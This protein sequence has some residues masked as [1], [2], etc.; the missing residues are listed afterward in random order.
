MFDPCLLPQDAKVRRVDLAADLQFSD[1]EDASRFL[2]GLSVLKVPGLPKTDAWRCEG[3]IETVYHRLRSRKVRWRVYDK[4]A[5]RASED[6]ANGDA[7]APPQGWIRMERQLHLAKP[8]QVSPDLLDNQRLAGMWLGEL[9][10]WS[11]VATD[12]VAGGLP[13]AQRA[14]IAAAQQGAITHAQ[15][16]R[17]LGHVALSAS[18]LAEQFW[19]GRPHTI[20][21]RDAELAGIGVALDGLEWDT[22]VCFPLGQILRGVRDAWLE[23]ET[24]RAA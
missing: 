20:R 3:A 22:S 9:A 5:E 11:R 17:L 21:R 18:G 23:Q 2:Y 14:V 8:R 6:S 10:P 24:D 7:S 19:N 13:A 4:T 16:E 1:P 15:A 12:S